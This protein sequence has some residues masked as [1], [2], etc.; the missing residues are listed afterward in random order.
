MT[1]RACD[2]SEQQLLIGCR[3][4][5]DDDNLTSLMTSN[6]RHRRHGAKIP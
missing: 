5:R 6:E 1:S 4:S 3:A 2:S